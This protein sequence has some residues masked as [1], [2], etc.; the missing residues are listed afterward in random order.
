MTKHRRYVSSRVIIPV[1]SYTRTI[2]DLGEKKTE[3]IYKYGNRR[4]SECLRAISIPF[5]MIV[6]RH[7]DTREISPS[8]RYTYVLK[9][10]GK[11]EISLK[12]SIC[13]DRSGHKAEA[14][15]QRERIKRWS[16]ALTNLIKQGNNSCL[17]K[18]ICI[19]F[20][21]Y[22]RSG[23]ISDLRNPMRKCFYPNNYRIRLLDIM[24]ELY[25]RTNTF[26]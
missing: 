3:M 1:S 4:F 18:F 5:Q 26:A 14:I 12:F 19:M 20:E 7:N 23:R 13:T 10:C 24:F 6:Q 15:N 22:N 8:Y 25:I 21:N 17:M 11:C 2:Y 16:Y 9:M